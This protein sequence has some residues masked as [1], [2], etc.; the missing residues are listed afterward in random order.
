MI[1]IQ[2]VL[3]VLVSEKN[4]LDSYA[5]V[6]NISDIIFFFIR[7]KAEH[8]ALPLLLFVI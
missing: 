5:V 1:L 6:D 2:M 3:L 4:L 8:I 7:V